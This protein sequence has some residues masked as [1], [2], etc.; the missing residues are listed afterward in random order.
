[1]PKI[2]YRVGRAYTEPWAILLVLGHVQL[3]TWP[4][5]KLLLIRYGLNLHA[6]PD[7]QDFG[8]INVRIL[9]LYY[10]MPH[11]AGGNAHDWIT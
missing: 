9:V 4:S 6:Q 7:L 10:A 2:A 8:V 5:L 1:M 3:D 11:H